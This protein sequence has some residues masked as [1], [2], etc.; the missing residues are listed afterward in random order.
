MMTLLKGSKF[1]FTLES[2]YD[3]D[4]LLYFCLCFVLHSNFDLFANKI[5]LFF[6]GNLFCS[7]FIRSIRRLLLYYV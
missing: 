6:K 4:V 5:I 2:F 7:G 3:I 1:A